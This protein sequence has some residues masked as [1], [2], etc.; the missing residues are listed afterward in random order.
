MGRVLKNIMS[1]ESAKFDCARTRI[2]HIESAVSPRRAKESIMIIY[3]N[4]ANFK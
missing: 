1:H 4:R 3:G 2:G